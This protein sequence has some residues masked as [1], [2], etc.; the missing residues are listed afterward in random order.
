[1]DLKRREFL[2]LAGTFASGAALTGVAGQLAGCGTSSKLSGKNNTFGLQLY[3]LRQDLPKDAKGVLKQVASFGYKQLEG[4]EGPKGIYWG[5]TNVEF[6]RYMDDLGMQMV[7]SHCNWKQ[8]LEKKADEA[9]AIGMK[10][11]MC[12][13]LGAQKTIDLYKK[14]ADD[15]NKAGQICKDRGIK[16]A[17]HNHDYSFKQLEGQYPQDILMQNSDKD[18]VDFEL[19]MY[20]IVASG[21]DANAWFQ[22][23]PNRFKLGHVKDRG[24]KETTTL[25]K[26]NIDYP[27]LLKTAQKG[28]M[29]YFIVEQEQYEGTTPL[30]AVKDN[31]EYMKRLKI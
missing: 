22:K 26:G 11:L 23:Y 3:T 30:A 9:A 24:G 1:M 6:K 27:S 12:P 19:D 4:F 7:S 13:S 17:Y 20:W 28:G 25:G 29:E 15:F 10:Y 5:M 8:D 18:L 21:Q 2:K 14:A 16:F 31:A